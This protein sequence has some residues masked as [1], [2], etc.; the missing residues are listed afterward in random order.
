MGKIPHLKG[1]P[2]LIQPKLI[3]YFPYNI[4]STSFYT[5]KIFIE[6]L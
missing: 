3:Q 5:H 6:L 2:D 1:L 4:I